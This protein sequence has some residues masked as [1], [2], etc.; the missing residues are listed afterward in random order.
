MHLAEAH[1]CV[2]GI[3]A[4]ALKLQVVRLLQAHEPVRLRGG[5]LRNGKAHRPKERATLGVVPLLRHRRKVPRR[6]CLR[7]A[8]R[9]VDELCAMHRGQLQWR[10]LMCR[11]RMGVARI[12]VAVDGLG[13]VALQGIVS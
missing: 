11:S 4:H 9:I 13:V 8:S 5:V 6:S 3:L 12:E 2:A 7:A 10:F 1:R